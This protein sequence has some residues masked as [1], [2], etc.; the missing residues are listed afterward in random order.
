MARLGES[1]AKGQLQDELRRLGRT[2][3]LIVD[4]VGSIPL[5]AEAANLFFQLVSA[6]YA[7]P[8]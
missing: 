7:E 6:R 1:H 4:E 3:L 2:P 8:P 5:E